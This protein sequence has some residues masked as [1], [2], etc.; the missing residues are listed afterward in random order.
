M[1]IMYIDVKLS[2]Y[3][4]CV[5]YSML[6]ISDVVI[7]VV[8]PLFILILILQVEAVKLQI[9]KLTVPNQSSTSSAK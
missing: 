6:L 1:K 3:L 4:S 2:F 8:R 9:T 7:V 5:Q